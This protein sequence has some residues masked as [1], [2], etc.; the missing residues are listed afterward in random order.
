MSTSLSIQSSPVKIMPGVDNRSELRKLAALVALINETF[1]KITERE[2]EEILYLEKS[3]QEHSF[4]S[5]HELRN[6]GIAALFVGIAT[7]GIGLASFGFPKEKD[8][9]NLVAQNGPSSIG[10]LFDATAEEKSKRL[11]A[12]AS[13]EMLEMQQKN[14][15][16]PSENSSKQTFTEALQSEIQLLRSSSSA[17]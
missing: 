12:T 2:S 9:V 3:Y 15:K 10:R 4:Q 6:R 17:N 8:F 13:I 14:Q 11:D 16:R 5:A 1:S 7:V